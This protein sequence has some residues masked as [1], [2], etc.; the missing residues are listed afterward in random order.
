MR[1]IK[2]RRNATKIHSRSL[3]LTSL[4]ELLELEDN[5]R[6]SNLLSPQK[7]RDTNDICQ[8]KTFIMSVDTVLRRY[9]VFKT[10]FEE[11]RNL[12][13]KQIYEFFI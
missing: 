9:Q 6:K 2:I 7:G 3:Y 8:L 13:A 4:A 11:S 1:F 12:R 5:L 10:N